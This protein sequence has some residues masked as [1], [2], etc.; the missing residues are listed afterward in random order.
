MRFVAYYRVSTSEQSNSG[1]GLEAQKRAIESFCRDGEIICSFTETESGGKNDR[2]KLLEAISCAKNNDAK[3][4]VAKLDRLSRNVAFIANLMDSKVPFV[5]ID[6]PTANEMTIHIIAAV[7]Q[8]E[9]KLIKERTKAALQS[10]KIQGWKAGN[11]NIIKAEPGKH[12]YKKIDGVSTKLT[13]EGEDR[14]IEAS[15][16]AHK[17]ALNREPFKPDPMLLSLILSLKKNGMLQIDIQKELKKSGR[18]VSAALVSRYIN[19]YQ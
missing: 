6:N 13:Q 19:K 10:K 4:V 18:T 2:P 17:A 7:A 16:L 3:L 15:V 11:P 1:L 5:A 9:R 14:E 8:N 12:F